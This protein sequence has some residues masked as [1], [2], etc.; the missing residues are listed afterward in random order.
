MMEQL[1]EKM[2]VRGL[3]AL[4]DAE[5]LSLLVG[6]E[7]LAAQLLETCSSLA[8]IA[9]EDR[10][11]LRTIGGLGLKRAQLLHVAAEFGR[12]V[13]ESRHGQAPVI[14]TS[15]AVVALMRPQLERLPYEECWALYL[16][17]SNRLIERCRI[18]QGGVQGTVVDHRLVVKR[19]LELLATKLILV[20]NHPSGAAEPSGADRQLTRRIAE[21]AALFDV[22]LL[23]HLIIS[24][25]GDFSFKRAKLL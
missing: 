25:E 5:L 10:A 11:R 18:S 17:S 12:R 9:D 20:H 6:D 24:R 7:R 14:D 13:A 1:I 22:R 8:Q 16:T 21:A 19:A 23:D 4:T 2:E 3:S 15:E